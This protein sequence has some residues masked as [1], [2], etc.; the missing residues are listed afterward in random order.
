MDS[1]AT[2]TD[3]FPVILVRSTDYVNN[4]TVINAIDVQLAI[5]DAV[6]IGMDY[7]CNANCDGRVT[8]WCMLHVTLGPYLS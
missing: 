1:H 2:A 7:N 8:L 6:G 4:D 3:S 5:N